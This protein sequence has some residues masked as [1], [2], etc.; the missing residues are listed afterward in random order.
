MSDRS[1]PGALRQAFAATAVLALAATTTVATATRVGGGSA[2]AASAV[3]A[4]VPQ[5]PHIQTDE[6]ASLRQGT[7]GA[8]DAR[9]ARLQVQ[10]VWLDLA[11][12][13]QLLRSGTPAGLDTLRAGESIRFTVLPG[14]AAAPTLKVI[15]VP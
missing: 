15:Y 12:T 1:L 8:V 9:G 5:P 2:P 14:S 7:I 10:G 6:S 3:Q 4:A 11:A 13:T